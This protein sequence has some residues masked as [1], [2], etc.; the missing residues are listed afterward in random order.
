MLHTE[1]CRICHGSADFLPYTSTPE[2]S[3]PI[4]RETT[5]I[6]SFHF[7]KHLRHV[8]NLR[9]ITAAVK[10]LIPSSKAQIFVPSFPSENPAMHKP[11]PLLAWVF[12]NLQKK[13]RDLIAGI[14]PLQQARL[15]QCSCSRLVIWVAFRRYDFKVKI[16]GLFYFIHFLSKMHSEMWRRLY[17]FHCYLSL[18][19]ETAWLFRMFPV[20]DELFTAIVS[21]RWRKYHFHKLSAALGSKVSRSNQQIPSGS[22][23]RFQ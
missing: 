14:S 4:F 13:H 2:I 1:I 20:T 5:K 6:K 19:E 15:T 23:I 11:K 7:I 8:P 21:Q 3:N 18:L 10:F 9:F 12:C 16:V 17:A 22:S